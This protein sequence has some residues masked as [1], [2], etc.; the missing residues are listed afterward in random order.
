MLKS[1]PKY[2]WKMQPFVLDGTPRDQ[3]RMGQGMSGNVAE[4][5]ILIINHHSAFHIGSAANTNQG[6]R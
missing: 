5:V 3:S 6:S 4:I 1:M 2:A